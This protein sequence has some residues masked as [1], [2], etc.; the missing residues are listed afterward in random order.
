MWLSLKRLRRKRD[1]GRYASS[2]IISLTLHT[3]VAALIAIYIVSR[4]VPQILIDA[5]PIVV[6]LLRLPSREPPP[7]RIEDDEPAR[8]QEAEPA[9]PVVIRPS[10][11]KPSATAGRATL[12]DATRRSRRAAAHAI[13]YT[14]PGALTTARGASAGPAGPRA[15]AP[16][17]GSEIK[18][19][20]TSLEIAT[21]S[22]DADIVPVSLP[23]GAELD[24]DPANV[25][26]H[27]RIF[28]SGR[29]LG[30]GNAAG[31][32]GYGS[33]GG[34]GGSRIGAYSGLMRGLAR[35]LVQATKAEEVD[36]VFIVDTTHSMIDNVRGVTAYADEFV[37]ILRWEGRRPRFGVVTFSDTIREPARVRGLTSKSGEFRNWLHEIEFTGGGDIP[38]SGLDAV[39][40]AANKIKFRRKSHRYFV[41]VSDGPF[42]DRDYDGQSEYTLDEVIREL[43]R[44][45]IVVDVVG[46]D[47]L[48]VKQLAWGTGGRA[49]PIPGRGYLEKVAPPLPVKANAALGVLSTKAEGPRDE[50]YVFPDPNRP[51]EWYELRWRLLSPR[52][53]KI[54]GEF[55]TRVS[56]SPSERKITFNPVFDESWFD[57]GLGYYTAIYRVTDSAGKSSVLRRIMDHR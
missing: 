48:P 53:I 6:T 33:G 5:T 17:V 25:R 13:D 3:I 14:P 39:M 30:A 46:I 57:G 28:A 29:G 31:G 34:G 23:D 41:F 4:H 55:V 51:A 54:Q 49:I 8:R 44:L 38:E 56:P 47:H 9:A 42:H 43:R 37:D 45:R 16:R 18:A 10:L 32:G 40:A 20:F 19:R 27:G 15:S 2:L 1:P 35:G 7:Q 24:G 12:A 36:I 21:R 11:P 52:G 26:A 50:L 22:V